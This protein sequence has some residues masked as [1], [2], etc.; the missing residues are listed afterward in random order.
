MLAC[1]WLVDLNR[2]IKLLKSL[3][4]GFSYCRYFCSSSIWHNTVEDVCW[5]S[6]VEG[7]CGTLFWLIE[8]IWLCNK[9]EYRLVIKDCNSL[10]TIYLTKFCNVLVGVISRIIVVFNFHIH[11]KLFGL[12]GLTFK[13]FFPFVL[14]QEA[15]EIGYSNLLI[16]NMLCTLVKFIICL[17]LSVQRMPSWPAIWFLTNIAFLLA[18]TLKW[19]SM[20][21][22]TIAL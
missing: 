9:M 14:N 18:I 5:V 7:E 11:K 21:T 10:Y 8:D 20:R 13:I 1:C 22:S 4:L 17:L 6:I 12:I 2:A 15:L 3:N 16:P 19:T